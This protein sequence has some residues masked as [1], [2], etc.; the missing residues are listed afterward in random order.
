MLF[1]WLPC[2]KASTSGSD[3]IASYFGDAET[4]RKKQAVFHAKRDD[5]IRN[6]WKIT[7][8]DNAPLEPCQHKFDKLDGMQFAQYLLIS[9]ADTALDIVKNNKVIGK[10]H[11]YHN[12]GSIERIRHS[13][14][15]HVLLYMP[16]KKLEPIKEDIL[17]PKDWACHFACN[18]SVWTID[19]L[20]GI[21]SW[22][23]NDHADLNSSD[24]FDLL[25]HA[26]RNKAHPNIK[27][28]PQAAAQYR[29]F[30]EQEYEK[31]V[32]TEKIADAKRKQ[33]AARLGFPSFVHHI[34][35]IEPNKPTWLAQQARVPLSLGKIIQDDNIVNVFHESDLAPPWKQRVA[36]AE[37]KQQGLHL[38]LK[39]NNNTK[40]ILLSIARFESPAEAQARVVQSRYYDYL[41]KGQHYFTEERVK[42]H[43]VIN[44]RLVGEFDLSLKHQFDPSGCVIPKS[45]E[46]AI[47]FQRGDTA[48]M[49]ASQDP[50]IS[51]LPLAKHID[52]V[53]VKK[54]Q[55]E[56][57]K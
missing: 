32:R 16:L 44:P 47:Y 46:S 34:S 41:Q 52:Q 43:T 28:S 38:I 10:V 33:L 22:F 8:G 23:G 24:F 39:N 48:V 12:Q 5:I 30:I 25:V 19:N 20:G 15:H 51:V 55:V 4:R 56:A 3:K 37:S 45:N 36:Q 26:L 29:L 57:P 18:Y 40:Q 49:I 42:N 1:L 7:L 17:S 21:I 27:F 11:V 2:T 50:R 6:K 35:D 54:L 14:L 53:L 13:L 31:R 9:D